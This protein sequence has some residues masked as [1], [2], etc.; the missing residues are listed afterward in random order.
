MEKSFKDY[1]RIVHM[2]GKIRKLRGFTHKNIAE[3]QA[4]RDRIDAMRYR[5]SQAMSGVYGSGKLVTA[6]QIAS[7]YSDIKALYDETQA[8]ITKYKHVIERSESIGFSRIDE[9]PHL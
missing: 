7:L 9:P 8:F 1:R 4:Q 2:R 6:D 5:L 3:F